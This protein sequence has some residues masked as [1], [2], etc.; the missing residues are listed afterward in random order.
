MTV[1]QITEAYIATF[2]LPPAQAEMVRFAA[3]AGDGRIGRILREA[4]DRAR[5]LDLA[6]V[7]DLIVH[8]PD[9]RYLWCFGAPAGL[10]SFGVTGELRTGLIERA[11][12]RGSALTMAEIDEAHRALEDVARGAVY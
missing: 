3:F 8:G 12:A 7:D 6:E 10:D 11:I 4:I 9:A 1:S 2:D 5:P